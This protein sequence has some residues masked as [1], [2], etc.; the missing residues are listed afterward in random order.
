[1]AIILKRVL[2]PVQW[3]SAVFAAAELQGMLSPGTAEPS[4]VLD[5]I[6]RQILEGPDGQAAV[7]DFAPPSSSSRGD[8]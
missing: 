2:G 7:K 4:C 5:A 6:R 3:L 8:R 1:M